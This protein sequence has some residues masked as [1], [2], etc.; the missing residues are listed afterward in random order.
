MIKFGIDLARLAFLRRPSY[1]RSDGVAQTRIGRA[2]PVP[3]A[4]RADPS[5]RSGPL[6]REVLVR[7][8]RG[9]A[10]AGPLF[11]AYASA[12]RTGPTIAIRLYA[13]LEEAG[14]AGL[15]AGDPAARVL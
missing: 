5:D 15:S 14:A 11:G 2:A 4:R 1:V 3:A 8:S 10:L 13:L 7:A 12:E 9:E 6:T